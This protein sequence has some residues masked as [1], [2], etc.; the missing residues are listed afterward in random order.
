MG[1]FEISNIETKSL[2]VLSHFSIWNP[3]IK[4]LIHL[5]HQLEDL[6]LSDVESHSFEHIVEL[7]HLNVIIFVVVN[8]IKHLLK[9]KTALF[10]NFYQMVKNLILSLKIL[11]FC[12]ELFDFVSIVSI[13]ETLQFGKFDNTVV[14]RVNFLKQ[15]TDL[16]SL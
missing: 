3:S 4:I 6:L 2:K 9:S 14:I 12:L 13:K 5:T 8:L 11:P 10:K 1:P 16:E 15:R 7:V